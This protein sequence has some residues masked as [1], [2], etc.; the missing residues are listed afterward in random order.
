MH[1]PFALLLPVCDSDNA[2][3]L[4]RAFRSAVHDQTLRP[5][6]VIVVRDGPVDDELTRCL[7]YL[8]ATSPVP[9]TFVPLAMNG[10]LGP[11]L[12]VGLTASRYDVVA[13]MDADDVSMAHRFQVQLPR[14]EE[15]DIVGAGLL[16][17]AEDTDQIVGRRIPPTSPEQI[18]RYARMHDPFNHPTVI[19]RRQ[20]VQASGGYGDMP[21]MEDYLLFARMLGDGAEPA[22]VAEPLVYYRV[23]AGAYQRRGGTTLLQSE[24][25]L[26][27][28]LRDD[29]FTSAAQ[30]VRNV[31]V[32]GPYRLVPWWCRRALYRSVVATR[33]EERPGVVV[34]LPPVVPRRL[35]A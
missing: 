29:G 31:A 30:Y 25:R 20:A 13:R 15:A 28:K 12:D 1:E 8:R 17:F 9:V 16:E 27:R 14:I 24:L 6:Q 11:A 4:H 2:D 33:F 21:R 32:R 7:D 34:S 35:V 10:G 18:R 19:Y 23:G 26:Q 22:N 5:D 3:H